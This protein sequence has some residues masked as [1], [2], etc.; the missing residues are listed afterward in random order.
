MR[1]RSEPKRVEMRHVHSDADGTERIE[2]GPTLEAVDT[3]GDPGVLDRMVSTSY[4]PRQ[5]V[6]HYA[7][8]SERPPSYPVK[9]PFVPHAE[10]WVTR[11]PDGD[12]PTGAR[13]RCTEAGLERVLG[14]L[15]A[16]SRAAG[17]EPGGNPPD[18]PTELGASRFLHE[19][20]F[21]RRGGALR[22]LIT[23]KADEQWLVQLLSILATHETTRL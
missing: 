1:E 11:F 2:D 14:E 19:V 3:G 10:S 7:A 18:W 13:W 4:G 8:T 9:F 6:I 21:M 15:V 12:G 16:Q 22:M 23:A 5:E 20:A 17:W